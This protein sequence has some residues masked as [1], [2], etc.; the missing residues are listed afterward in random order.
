MRKSFR[1]LLIYS[2]SLM[3]VVNYCY[4]K[5]P[6]I[7]MYLHS[8]KQCCFKNL[9]IGILMY[10]KL[11]SYIK[12]VNHLCKNYYI[13]YLFISFQQKTVSLYISIHGWWYKFV[14]RCFSCNIL[15]SFGIPHYSFIKRLVRSLGEQTEGGKI[16][17]LLPLLH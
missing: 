11:G 17:G 13:K 6:N 12:A 15:D 3:I 10:I 9:N 4:F 8:I 2:Y 1:C 5:N 16:M 14:Y 7:I